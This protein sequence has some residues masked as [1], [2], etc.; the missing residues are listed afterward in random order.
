MLKYKYDLHYHLSIKFT[1]LSFLMNWKIL[2]KSKTNY[3]E[4][5]LTSNLITETIQEGPL[6]KIERIIDIVQ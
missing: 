1:P 4:S 5:K 3:R 2:F 6:P